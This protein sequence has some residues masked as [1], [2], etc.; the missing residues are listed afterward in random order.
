MDFSDD[1]ND[2]FDAN[3][4]DECW[5]QLGHKSGSNDGLIWCLNTG[6]GD[7]IYN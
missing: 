7:N 4:S 5:D 3:T 1:Y 6:F 2:M